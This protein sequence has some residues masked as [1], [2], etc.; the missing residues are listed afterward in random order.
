MVAPL[1]DHL[2]TVDE[3]KALYEELKKSSPIVEAWFVDSEHVEA[4]QRHSSE[5]VERLLSFLSRYM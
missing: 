5:Y 2:I 4:W 1:R 3:Y